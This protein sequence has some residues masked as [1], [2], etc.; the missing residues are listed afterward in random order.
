MSSDTVGRRPTFTV[1]DRK[2]TSQFDKRFAEYPRSRAYAACVF[3]LERHATSSRSAWT[4]VH[5]R[6][7]CLLTTDPDIDDPRESRLESARPT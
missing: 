3:P 6:A 1:F 4:R 2:R 7:R 5:F